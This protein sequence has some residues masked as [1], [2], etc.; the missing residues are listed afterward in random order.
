[1]PK[2]KLNPKNLIK[3]QESYRLV[4]FLVFNSAFGKHSN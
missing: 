2:A 4:E 1:M 3:Q